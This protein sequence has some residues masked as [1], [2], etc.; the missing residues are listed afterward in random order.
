MSTQPCIFCKIVSAEIPADVVYKDEQVTAFRDIN[1]VGPT[2]VL[3]IP[4]KH[5]ESV[6]DAAQDDEALL[7][8]IFLTARK[9]AEIDGLTEN[10]YRLIVNTGAH[11]NQTVSHLHLHVIGGQPMKY[12]MG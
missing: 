8:H 4:N 12:P 10:G 6:N 7:G 9:I 5:I 3:I 11:G 2:H 1:P